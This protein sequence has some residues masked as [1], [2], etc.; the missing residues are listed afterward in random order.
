MGAKPLSPASRQGLLVAVEGPQGCESKGN[1]ESSWGG[2][3]Q[4]IAVRLWGLAARYADA[5][6]TSLPLGQ[7]EGLASE[8][9]KNQFP[10]CPVQRLRLWPSELREEPQEWEGEGGPSSE[11]APA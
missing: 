8:W 5:P 11:G 2:P 1:G 4:V 9:G 10:A 7:E 3:H 6:I